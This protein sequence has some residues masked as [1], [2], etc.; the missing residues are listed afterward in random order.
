MNRNYQFQGQDTT[1]VKLNTLNQTGGT[2]Q[3]FDLGRQTIALEDLRSVVIDSSRLE[4]KKVVPV[5]K[6][7]PYVPR[8][9]SLLHPEYNIF[10]KNFDFPTRETL[11]DRF[12]FEPFDPNMQEKLSGKKLVLTDVSQSVVAEKDDVLSKKIEAS[13]RVPE[14]NGFEATDWMLGVILVSLLLFGWIRVGYGK[15]VQMA[16]QAS[17][18]F[19]TARRIKEEANILRTRVFYFLNVLFFINL[20]LFI[21]QVADYNQIE[22]PIVSGIGVF[23]LV[24]AGIL[25]I[26]S[27]K[28]VLL[29][30]LDFIFLAKGAFIY[31][32]STVFIYNRMIGLFLLPIITIVPFISNRA[33]PWLFYSGFF[34]ILGFYIFR[35]FRGLQ[36]GFKNRF[37]IFYL[38]LYLC[39]LEILPVWVLYH[40]VKTQA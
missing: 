19:F 15:F 27:L 21:T 13:K 35:I 18:N 30:V 31:Y 24:L 1:S 2:N 4:V 12:K 16:M 9:D 10:T 32:N 29:A 34:I 37:S 25:L 7:I 23:F 5:I 39:A 26:Y 6:T 8:K 38:I 20:S 17:Y 40:W 36:I 22:I 3:T 28:G 11:F 14:G 33:T